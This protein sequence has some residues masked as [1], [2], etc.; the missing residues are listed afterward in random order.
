MSIW[1]IEIIAV[2]PLGYQMCMIL[3]H[4]NP[5]QKYSMTLIAVDCTFISPLQYACG[6]CSPQSR[7]G[8]SLPPSKPLTG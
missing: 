1:D 8:V 2:L 7:H 4:G 6:I 3:E 5:F